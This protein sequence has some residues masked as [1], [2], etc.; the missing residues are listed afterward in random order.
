MRKD[1]VRIS[2]LLLI[3]ALLAG[4]A[5][6]SGQCGAKRPEVSGYVHA[7]WYY[8]THVG[9]YPQHSFILRRIRVRFNYEQTRLQSRI[10]LGCDELTPEI[11]DAFVGYQASSGLKLVVGLGKLP[12]SREELTAASKLLAIERGITNEAFADR[13]FLGCD[14]GL[15]AMG[16]LRLGSLLLSYAAG[17]YNG[18]GTR[19]A[20][21]DNDA[22]QFAQRIELKPAGGVNVGLNATQRHDSVTGRL[23]SAYGA[24]AGLC[25]GNVDAE[26][27]LL[28]G[29]ASAGTTMLGAI[30]TGAYRI[31]PVRPWLRLERFYQ[32]ILRH[33]DWRTAATVGGTWQLQQQ[34]QLK[35][36]W[37][38]DLTSRPTFAQEIRIQT[39]AS[40]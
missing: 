13:G 1:T 40:F 19:L 7:Q 38:A 36:G 12:F 10:E 39:Q 23:A 28:V 22:K 11:K 20:R 21:D 9:V 26:A 16:D 5:T 8:D 15:T 25:L 2:A 3:V 32:D 31:G 34:L 29:A 14:I 24:D 17:V 33:S 37:T 18:T 6:G 30:L 4:L 27:E 35:V